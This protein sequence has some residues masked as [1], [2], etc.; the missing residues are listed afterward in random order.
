MATDPTRTKTLRSDF[1]AECYRR[2]RPLKGALR[3]AI[4]DLDVLGLGE[5]DAEL[6]DVSPPNP[7]DFRFLTD[8]EKKAQFQAWLDEQIDRGVLSAGS[9][10]PNTRDNRNRARHWTAS[11][12]RAA[13]KSGVRHADRELRKQGYDVPTGQ[14]E[15]TFN[16]PI[17]QD[18]LQLLYTRVYDALE[19]VTTAMDKELSRTLT[20]GLSQGW[21][22]RKT[23]SKLNDRVDKIGIT[24][25]R[26][27]ARTETIYAHAESTLDRFESVGVTE[28]TADVEFQDA[29]D[30]RVCPI[31]ESLDGNRYTIDEARG[32]V[33]AHPRCRCS[34]SPI[35]E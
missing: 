32:T 15:D 19:G 34:W 33:P 27:M 30:S 22:P 1:S 8:A 29:G 21:N 16:K 26:T 12:V 28:V 4:V 14:L 20:E 5:S 13:S 7:D 9:A 31:C 17:H 6:A 11:Y 23:A 35:V 3:T 10:T 18:K 24:R 2:F 25:A